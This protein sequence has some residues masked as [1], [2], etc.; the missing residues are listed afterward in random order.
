MNNGRMLTVVSLDPVSAR[1]NAVTIEGGQN[2]ERNAQFRYLNEHIRKYGDA[3]IR[4]SMALGRKG[5]LAILTMV[6]MNA[7]RCDLVRD[8][9]HAFPARTTRPHARSGLAS[10]PRGRREQLV[11]VTGQAAAAHHQ[12]CATARD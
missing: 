4:S 9:D 6:V 2:S 12:R 3:G 11:P 7:T 5:R 10:G 8:K 1:G